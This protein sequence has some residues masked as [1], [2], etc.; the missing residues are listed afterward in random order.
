MSSR[1]YA[2]RHRVPGRHRAPRKLRLPRALTPTFA[3]PTA[4][5]ATLVFTTTGATVAGSAPVELQTTTIDLALAQSQVSE[6]RSD[7]DALA[8]RRT[9]TT[10]QLALLQGRQQEDDRVARAQVREEIAEKKRELEEQKRAE[11]ERKAE[12]E[13]RQSAQRWVFP[14]AGGTFTSGYGSRWGRLHAGI[15]IAAP[16]GTPIYSVSSGTVVRISSAGGCGR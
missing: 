4:A 13:R 5:A 3:L 16:I 11:A 9:A 7:T 8:E 14:I 12:E 2:G 6:S 15:D 1:S 10:D